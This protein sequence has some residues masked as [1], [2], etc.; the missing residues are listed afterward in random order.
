M[1]TRF[2][3]TNF[4]GF[5]M[6]IELDLSTPKDYQFN[7]YAIKNGV[8]KNAIVYG[9]N[10][11][12]KTNLSLAIFDIVNHL[13]QK[14]R[15]PDYYNNFVYAGS[16]VREVSFEYTFMF[17]RD[18]IQYDYAKNDKGML[19]RESLQFNGKSIFNKN[20]SLT[21]DATQ[22][23]IDDAAKDSIEVSSNA[24]SMVNYLLTSFPL[25]KNHY[26]IKLRDFVASMLWFRCLEQRE[27]IGLETAAYYLDDYIISNK[28]VQEFADFLE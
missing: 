23:K 26:L 21:V 17:D 7:T 13:S 6:S 15:K 4:R 14:W 2:A 19:V 22:F 28:L 12:G 16:S 20:E 9:P 24:V 11:C 18:I 8:I 10:G 27:F 25:Q 5:D 1:L 3:V